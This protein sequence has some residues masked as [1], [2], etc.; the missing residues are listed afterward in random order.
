MAINQLGTFLFVEFRNAAGGSGSPELMQEMGEI[1]QRPGV[2]GS[3]VRK[4]G[5]KGEPFQMVSGVD[6]LNLSD[7]INT[8][9]N[10][11]SFVNQI[12][13]RIIWNG[14]LVL[15]LFALRLVP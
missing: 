14:S 7:G 1:I 4:F 12:E 11:K 6:C 5:V 15:S 8:F 13:M 3:G 9:N 10:Y 2:N